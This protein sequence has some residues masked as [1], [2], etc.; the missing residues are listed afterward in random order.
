MK[1]YQLFSEYCDRVLWGNDLVDALIRQKKIQK[2]GKVE[3]NK[4]VPGEIVEIKSVVGTRDTTGSRRGNWEYESA[5]CETESGQFIEID[6]RI[7]GGL[8]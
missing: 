4:H 2:S 1:R 6:G 7:V 3:N 5:I 8:Q